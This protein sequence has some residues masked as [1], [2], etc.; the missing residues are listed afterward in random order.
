MNIDFSTKPK[1]SVHLDPVHEAYCRYI[2]KTPPNQSHI[3]VSRHHVIGQ[4]LTA[5]TDE[6]PFLEKNPL[7]KNSVVFILPT[8][9]VNHYHVKR[10]FLK[11]SE[12]DKQKFNDFVKSEFNLWMREE[13]YRGYE[14]LRWDQKIIVEAVCRKL[15]VRNN[16]INSA[17]ITKNDYRNRVHVERQRAELL[18]KL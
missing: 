18:E 4:R 16:T 9:K 15:N 2:F 5:V 7:L 17:T 10:C 3:V 11:V 6:C 1:V 12:W 8:D 13:F 14:I